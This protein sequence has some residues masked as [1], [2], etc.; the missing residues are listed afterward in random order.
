MRHT[1]I[2]VLDLLNLV[3]LIR[4]AKICFIQFLSSAVTYKRL[5][6]LQPADSSTAESSS[7]SSSSQ[8]AD[9][10]S[11]DQKPSSAVTANGSTKDQD[12][13]QPRRI[14]VTAVSTATEPFAGTSDV[15]PPGTPTTRRIQ[16]TT[17]TTTPTSQ[18]ENKCQFYPLK[19]S[20]HK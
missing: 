1:N 5:F 6:S 12:G 20:N 15:K 2:I 10:T 19:C 17:L 13:K 16:V 11:T 9:R 14:E 18:G 3:S 8:P 7:N 4:T